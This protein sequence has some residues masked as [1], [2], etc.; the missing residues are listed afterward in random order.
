MEIHLIK[1]CNSSYMI[2]VS[3]FTEVSELVFSYIMHV[4][5]LPVT[6]ISL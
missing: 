5:K 3:Y 2:R 1:F 4:R 6:W